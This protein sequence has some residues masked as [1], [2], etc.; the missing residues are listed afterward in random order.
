[1]SA[2]AVNTIMTGAAALELYRIAQ[3]AITNALKHAQCRNIEI[4]LALRAT[5]VELLIHD[6]GE[7]LNLADTGG[8]E[9]IGLRT[10]RYRA[11]RAGGTLELRSKQGH[12]TTVR[13]LVP[14]TSGEY[15]H[16]AADAE[17]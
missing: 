11:A 5:A 17:I 15:V 14:T 9:G 8:G 4:Q 16:P 6:D 10:M 1:M 12:G 7:G 3:E 13:V 2:D